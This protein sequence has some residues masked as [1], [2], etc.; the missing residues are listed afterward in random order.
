MLLW[1]HSGVLLYQPRTCIL[2]LG[3]T[4]FPATVT[5]DP[6]CAWA[7]CSPSAHGNILLYCRFHDLYS[8]RLVMTSL[9]LLEF[10]TLGNRFDIDREAPYYVPYSYGCSARGLSPACH[11]ACLQALVCCAPP[12]R[13]R[14]HA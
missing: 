14:T 4:L 12:E 13:E 7:L 8:Y 11:G 9:H 1:L 2:P 3:K 10:V 6:C 5:V